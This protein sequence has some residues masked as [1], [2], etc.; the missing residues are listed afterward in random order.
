M[1]SLLVDPFPLLLL[2]AAAALLPWLAMVLTPFARILIVLSVLRHAIGTPQT[3]PTAILAGLAIVLS[4]AILQPVFDATSPV[5]A[6]AMHEA[7]TGT[8]L[9]VALDAD[10]LLG[11]WQAFLRANTGEA[12]HAFARSLL[13]PAPAITTEAPTGSGGTPSAAPNL[14]LAEVPSPPL[15]LADSAAPP[16]SMVSTFWA[17]AVGF[18]LTELKRAFLMAFLFGLPFLVVELVGAGVLMSLGMHM[19]APPTVTL[20]FKLLLMAL[21]NGWMLVC[22]ALVGGYEMPSHNEMAATTRDAGALVCPF[23]PDEA[24]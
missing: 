22:H 18:A 1:S 3:P 24:P 19:L 17:D 16:P 23:H 2:L 7:Q 4:G 5:L 8:P 15:D 11:P 12:E 20:P 10:A 13:A 6:R 14:C 21:A 9:H